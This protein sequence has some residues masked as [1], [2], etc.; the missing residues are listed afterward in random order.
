MRSEEREWRAEKR[1]RKKGQVGGERRERREKIKTGQQTGGREDKYESERGKQE[2]KK[3]GRTKRAYAR[4][5]TNNT[6]I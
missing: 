5:L 6:N 2:R 3:G 4:I 1:E